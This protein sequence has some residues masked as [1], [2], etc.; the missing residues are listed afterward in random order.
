MGWMD[1]WMD[2]VWALNEEC[3]WM[4]KYMQVDGWIECR[5]LS[6]ERGWMDGLMCGHWMK[7]VDGCVNT[8]RWMD[9]WSVGH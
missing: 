9:G 8:C 2:G 4:C 5:A 6:E 7:N 1:G 3:G